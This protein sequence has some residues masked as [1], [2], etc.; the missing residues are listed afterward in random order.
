MNELMNEQ[1]AAARL[2]PSSSPVRC[3][4]PEGHVD[5][6]L[7]KM[8]PRACARRTSSEETLVNQIGTLDVSPGMPGLV[9]FSSRV[10]TE[11]LLRTA[12]R[13]R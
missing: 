5:L 9:Q 11:S 3:R 6:V 2:T 1:V 7:L 13:P 10:R 12:P 4:V 8:A